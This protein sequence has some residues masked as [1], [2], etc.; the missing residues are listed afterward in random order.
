MD[1]ISHAKKQF[2]AMSILQMRA[3]KR[4]PSH[5]N[6]IIVQYSLSL[7]TVTLVEKDALLNL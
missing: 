7:L 6:W 3:K 4:E 5:F 2:C 1:E